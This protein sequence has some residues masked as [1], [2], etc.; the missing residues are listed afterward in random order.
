VSLDSVL[1]SLDVV[2]DSL[3]L[4][5]ASLYPG[6]LAIHIVEVSLDVGVFSLDFISFS[7]DEYIRLILIAYT[8]KLWLV[9]VVRGVCGVGLLDL[10]LRPNVLVSNAHWFKPFASTLVPLKSVLVGHLPVVGRRLVAPKSGPDLLMHLMVK[11][12]WF[13]GMPCPLVVPALT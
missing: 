7:L 10:S 3:Y 5:V 11:S 9:I 12:H 6:A 8:W 1:L 13:S 2:D 4:I